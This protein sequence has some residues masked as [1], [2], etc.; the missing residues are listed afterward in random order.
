MAFVQRYSKKKVSS[1]EY[2]IIMVFIIIVCPVYATI[3]I[4][5]IR[6]GHAAVVIK[7]HPW[8]E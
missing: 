2:N 5:L 3:F 1:S 7:H 8:W 6:F 4:L